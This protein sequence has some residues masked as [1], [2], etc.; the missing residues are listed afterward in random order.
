MI[1]L[2]IPFE[3]ECRKIIQKIFYQNFGLLSE[4]IVPLV[5]QTRIVLSYFCSV[6]DRAWLESNNFK[7]F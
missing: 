7:F 5:K 1:N 2:G 3:E 4:V 6:E